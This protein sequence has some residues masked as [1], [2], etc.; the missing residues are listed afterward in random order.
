MQAAP[1]TTSYDRVRHRH[2]LRPPSLKSSHDDLIDSAT[3]LLR[4]DETARLYVAAGK[5]TQKEVK[6]SFYLPDKHI[7][8]LEKQVCDSFLLKTSQLGIDWV[9]GENDGIWKGRRNVGSW[10]LEDLSI[11]K[12]NVNWWIGRWAPSA[13]THSSKA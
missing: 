5:Y 4:K 1:T 13:L 12:S 11:R 8:T 2:T 7:N 9:V 6:L 3:K 10:S